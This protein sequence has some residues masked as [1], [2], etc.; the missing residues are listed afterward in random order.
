VL[1]VVAGIT[2]LAINLALRQGPFDRFLLLLAG[3]LATPGRLA[4]Q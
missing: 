3:R 1:V 2:F 4:A